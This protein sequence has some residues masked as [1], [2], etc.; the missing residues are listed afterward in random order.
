MNLSVFVI[1]GDGAFSK[2]NSSFLLKIKTG[3]LLFDCGVNAFN[4][5]MEN[6]LNI[7]DVFISHTHFD[8]IS[9]LE[10]LCYYNY[11]IKNSA[12]NIYAV[13]EVLD[14]LKKMFSNMNV[15]YDNGCKVEA[16]IARFKTIE[17]LNYKFNFGCLIRPLKGNHVIKDNYGLI[18]ECKDKALIITGDTKASE[19]IAKEIDW[20]SSSKE[21]I[22]VFHDYS[23]FD[24]VFK[25]VHCCKT[26]YEYYYKDLLKLGNIRWFKYH[27]KTFNERYKYKEINI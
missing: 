8:H 2:D 17:D 19:E 23:E 27:N 25:N 7:T 12:T 24:N 26:D 16:D 15:E 11:F 22:V 10:Q 14:E 13:G 5:I 20:L 9:G 4:Y 3:K 1:G 21:R 6:D 18:I